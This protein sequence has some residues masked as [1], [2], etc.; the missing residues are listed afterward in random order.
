[1][2]TDVNNTASQIEFEANTCNWRQARENACGENTIS[3]G[4]ASHVA[5][6]RKWRVFCEPITDRSNAKPKQTRI[7]FDS[8]LKT[9][10]YRTFK[11]AFFDLSDVSIVHWMVYSCPLV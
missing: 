8:Q 5:G 6:L 4:F 3:F 9:A 10:L 2:G 7:T 1:M 11:T